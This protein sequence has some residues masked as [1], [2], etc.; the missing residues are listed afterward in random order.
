MISSTKTE[1]SCKVYKYYKHTSKSTKI[2][3]SNKIKKQTNKKQT[4][5]QEKVRASET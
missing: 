4:S 2:N 5:K 3:N 1:V